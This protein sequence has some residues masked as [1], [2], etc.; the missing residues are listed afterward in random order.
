MSAPSDPESWQFRPDIEGLR[1]VA[2]IGVILFHAGIPGV[3]GGFLG[4]DV[5]FVLSGFLIT[6]ILL[7]EVRKTGTISLP[8]FWARRARRLLPAATLVSLVTLFFFVRLDSPFA[9]QRLAISAIS[10]ATYWSNLLF[11]HRG[12]DYFDQSVGTDPFLHTWSLAVEEQ[13]Y[14]LFA[15]GV[16]LVTLVL[17]RVGFAGLRNRLLQLT[18]ALS[19]VSLAGFL[20]LT[21]TR[22]MFAFYGLP[23]RAWEFGAGGILAL[24]PAAGARTGRRSAAGIAL[25]ALT[26]VVAAFFLT[27][28]RSFLSG[29]VT[30]LPVL[31]TAVLIR[32]GSLQTGVVGRL[33]EAA[34]MRWLGRLSYSWYLWHW[35]LTVYWAKLVPGNPIPLSIGMPLASLG[36]AQ[37]TY[38]LV[39]QPARDSRRLR[40]ARRGLALALVLAVV[41]SVTALGTR[42]RSE[43]RLRGPEYAYILAA[44]NAR[45]RIHTDGCD[46]ERT[47]TEKTE[48]CVYGVSGSDTTIVIFGDSH[49]AQWFSALEPLA[50]RRGWRLVP[51]IRSGCPVLSVRILSANPNRHTNCDRWR[52]SALERIGE[53][54]PVLILISNYWQYILLDPSGSGAHEIAAR[55]PD[56]W[57]RELLNTLSR[58]PDTGAI[59]LLADSPTPG[60]DVPTCLIEY[61]GE[62]ERCSFSRQSGTSPQITEV[63]RAISR[64]D[65]RVSHLDLT[66]RICEG[67]ICPAARGDTA[68][69][70]DNNHLSVD[71]AASLGRWLAPAVDSLIAA[72][73]GRGRR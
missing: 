54:R 38:L 48:R 21:A 70:S 60:R 18:V 72:R 22:P 55:Q 6:G 69:Y 10:F 27:S 5:F 30:M 40:P 14:L 71:F 53:L 2:I 13:Y 45:T 1:A 41:A 7:D 62:V 20:V 50:L 57:R 39:E 73:P 9:E 36:L 3:T 34:P 68:R 63:E 56:V 25:L 42:W 49:A 52:E 46:R 32:L 33:L 47:P 23:T 4:V 19:L 24:L 43:R 12:A 15:P 28:E 59:L 37:L 31:G 35:P 29:V 66:D 65:A 58:L 44:K 67:A 51:L 11:W 64:S 61:V 26:A 16:L 8:A 17:R